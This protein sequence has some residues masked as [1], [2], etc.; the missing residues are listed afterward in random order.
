MH[1]LQA[2]DTG[3]SGEG[4]AALRGADWNDEDDSQ[5]EE[6]NRGDFR[7]VLIVHVNIIELGPSSP[8]QG[9]SK[10]LSPYS[11]NTIISMG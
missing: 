6:E 3:P 5:G 9:V 11:E 10:P 4:Q 8:F 2:G 1:T 7:R